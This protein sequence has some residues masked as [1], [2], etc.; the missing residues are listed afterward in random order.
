MKT[1][2]L[3]VIVG[4]RGFFPGHLAETGR[5]TV[6]DVLAAEGIKTIALG[7]QE[8]PYGSVESVADAQKCADLFKAH[9]EEIDGILVTLPNFGDER[10]VAN[11]IRWSGLDVPVLIQATPDDMTK[12]TVADRRDSFCGKMSV[13]NN[14][15]QYGIKYS[16]T[17]QHTVA[18]D[19]AAFLADL[20]QFVGVCRTVGGLRG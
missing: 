4:T 5:Q 19:S 7:A 3:G 17:A 20:R 15:R 14:L 10:A 16:L 11:S 1:V 2:T 18:P 9:A 12:M 6:L 8:T 13:C